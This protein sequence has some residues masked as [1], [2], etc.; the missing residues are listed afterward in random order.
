MAGCEQAV[1]TTEVFGPYYTTTLKLST[2]SDVL[3]ALAGS[4]KEL[5]SQSQSVAASYGQ[6]AEGSKLWFN[7][8]AFDED[9]LTAVRKYAMHVEES[10]R[11]YIIW[12]TRSLRLDA[13]AVVPASVLAEPYESENA[14]SLAILRM[15]RKDFSDDM[16]QVSFDS[17]D[18]RSA[19]LV[20]MNALN[21]V[22]QTL[23][24]SPAKASQLGR[25]EGMAFEL[26]TMG[27]GRV[28]VLLN[29]DVVTVKIKAGAA[30]E[31]FEN[32]PDVKN[33]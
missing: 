29:N 25:V 27:P 32:Q 10:V 2:S 18:L 1:K 6:A 16:G 30:A 31:G 28:R 17:A 14:R 4:E 23:E 21:T 13:Q 20:A 26:M 5:V 19:A 12:P 11:P 33:M 3:N 15:L 7:M 9:N 24:D 8:V 22:V